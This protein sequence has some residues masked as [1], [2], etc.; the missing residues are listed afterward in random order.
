MQIGTVPS[1]LMILVTNSRGDAYYPAIGRG[2]PD[3]MSLQELTDY[4][5]LPSGGVGGGESHPE[6]Y[7]LLI[8]DNY[9]KFN[10]GTGEKN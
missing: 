9:A 3:R 1:R 2:V 5:T 10:K 7:I 4:Y 6:C 8:S